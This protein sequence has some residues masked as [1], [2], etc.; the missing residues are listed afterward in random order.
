[1][2]YLT[3]LYNRHFNSMAW[4]WRNFEVGSFL[5][6]TVDSTTI[7]TFQLPTNKYIWL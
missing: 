2:G 5:G 3:Q 6:K 7:H 4:C 1:M